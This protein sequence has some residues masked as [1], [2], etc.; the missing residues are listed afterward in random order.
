[1]R[2]ASIALVCLLFLT[3][4]GSVKPSDNGALVGFGSWG[5]GHTQPSVGLRTTWTN[6]VETTAEWT[7]SI[8]TDGTQNEWGSFQLGADIPIGGSK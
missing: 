3:A 7:P 6:G 4:C 5:R 1:M 8:Y 2:R